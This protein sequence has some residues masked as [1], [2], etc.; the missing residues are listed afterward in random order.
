MVSALELG[1]P[2]GFA[3]LVGQYRV[4]IAPELRCLSPCLLTCLSCLTQP[5][6]EH[7]V[8]C[9]RELFSSPKCVFSLVYIFQIISYLPASELE[10]ENCG[11]EQLR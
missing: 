3:L 2:L 7:I 8:F 10:L 1:K 4:G 6:G 11:D 9:H 5:M